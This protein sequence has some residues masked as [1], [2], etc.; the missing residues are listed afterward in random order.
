MSEGRCG[1]AAPA[2][3]L[4]AVQSVRRGT[5]LYSPQKTQTEETPGTLRDDSYINDSKSE[6]FTLGDLNETPPS[7]R[8]GRVDREEKRMPGACRRRSTHKVTVHHSP[9]RRFTLQ[10]A[11]GEYPSPLQETGHKQ[12]VPSTYDRIE[13]TMQEQTG[14]FCG[15]DSQAAES[16]LNGQGFDNACEF[17]SRIRSAGRNSGATNAE[18][19]EGLER[20]LSPRCVLSGRGVVRSS[21]WARSLILGLG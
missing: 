20:S 8:A 14:D 5:R 10:C 13:R 15:V 12:A 4:P 6:G 19:R 9:R 2:G 3:S 11:P 7:T 21:P 1:Y 17:G 16:G 18:G